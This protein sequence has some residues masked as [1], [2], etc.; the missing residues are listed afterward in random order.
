MGVQNLVNNEMKEPEKNFDKAIEFLENRKVESLN[1]V[2]TDVEKANL[3]KEFDKGIQVLKE[4]KRKLVYMRE[5]TEKKKNE[6]IE[7]DTKTKE[8]KKLK[9]K[10]KISSHF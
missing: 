6:E 4:R 3:S 7:R 8:S 5:L 2:T 1:N 9:E 10:A